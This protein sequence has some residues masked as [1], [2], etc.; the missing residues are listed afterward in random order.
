M[1]TLNKAIAIPE[2]SANLREQVSLQH[3]AVSRGLEELTQLK[4]IV[5][6]NFIVYFFDWEGHSKL[7][8]THLALMN[9]SWSVDFDPK[10]LTDKSRCS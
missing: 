9:Y 3:R 8:H 4:Q 5:P 7:G 6:K 2:C 1:D 10:E